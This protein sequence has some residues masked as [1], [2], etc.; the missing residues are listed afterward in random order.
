MVAVVVDDPLRELTR[1]RAQ[2]AGGRAYV[3]RP[4][5]TVRPG[6]DL[7]DPETL[8]RVLPAAAADG[9]VMLLCVGGVG[10]LRTGAGL[11]LNM[12][13]LG[14][15][16]MLLLAPERRVCERMWE[17][18]ASVACVWWPSKILHTRRPESLYN[19][20]FSP[21]AL[22]IFE[23]RKV[24]L[25]R[26]VLEH[27]LN[28]LHLDA[29]SVRSAATN[30]TGVAAHTS[31]KPSTPVRRA[32]VWFA[33]PYPLFKGV[34]AAHSLIAQVDGPFLNA[35]IFYVQHVEYGD[36]TAWALEELNRRIGRLTYHPE[37]V[38]QLPHSS[39]ARAP[40]FANADEQA[41]PNDVIAS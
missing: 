37:S 38:A 22:A 27:G 31:S 40:Y 18:F 19:T 3:L 39:W 23:A 28:V 33:N 25:Q 26:M 16:H 13:S 6:G 29:D 20:R 12:R 10:A 41:G 35:G 1:A 17:A 11:V 14:L 34:M 2:L 15:H 24:L 4:R 5:K 7:D 9:E 30:A 8:S 21:L 36:A 32:Q